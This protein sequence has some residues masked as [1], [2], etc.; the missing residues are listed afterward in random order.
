MKNSDLITLLGQYPANAEV[1]ISQNSATDNGSV[2]HHEIDFVSKNKAGISFID[3]GV[4]RVL[5][6][7]K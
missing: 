7:I 6:T 5:S 1:C 3:L 2:D 4:G